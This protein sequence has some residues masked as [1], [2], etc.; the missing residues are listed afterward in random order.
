MR[1]RMTMAA[2]AALGLVAALPEA[3]AQGTLAARVDAVR[4]GEVRVEYAARPG[5][6]GDG[7]GMVSFGR[8]FH[9]ATMEG[10]GTMRG[11][12]RCI[13]GPAR[14][15]IVRREGQVTSVRAT[16]AEGSAATRV[17]AAEAAA[18][19]LG[20][21]RAAEGR[22][23]RGALWAAALAD[24]ASPSRDF[25]AY[26]RDAGRP[27]SA[28]RTAMQLAGATGDASLVPE[29]EQLA[30]AAG[31]EPTRAKKDEGDLAKGAVDAL[32]TIPDDAGLDALLQLAADAPRAS[33]RGSALFM[34]AQAGDPRG[35]RLARETAERA[36][37]PD[38]L[39]KSATFAV[40]NREDVAAADRA[41]AR[42]LFPKASARGMRDVIL[43][44]LAQH[45]SED[46]RA[47]VLAL[48]RDASL[49]TES[50]RQAVFWAGQGGATIRDLLATYEGLGDREVKEHVIFA[51]SQREG[52]AATDALVNIARADGDR[53][54]RKKAVFWLGQRRDARAAQ[55]L[56]DLVNRQE[57]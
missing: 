14:A 34:A 26:A 22:A 55:Y 21:A 33:V 41:W 40:L 11:E 2:V 16:V 12:R 52:D 35:V 1:R 24:S 5:A 19:F 44:G 28:R 29:L 57:E 51:I 15:T 7:R 13:A 30:R 42:A 39:R 43:M 10:W 6:C 36:S 27:W 47:W 4:D 53:E 54:M 56:A 8:M 20:L 50:R 3:R 37:E 18:Y 45:G 9:S 31:P 17:G 32:A 23:A 46:D 48:A 25:L 49:S 38:E